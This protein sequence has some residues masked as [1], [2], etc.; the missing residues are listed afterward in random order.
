MA[1][2]VSSHCHAGVSEP[3]PAR[4]PMHHHRLIPSVEHPSIVPQKPYHHIP[5]RPRR[6]AHHSIRNLALGRVLLTPLDDLWRARA[7]VILWDRVHHHGYVIAAAEPGLWANRLA[8]KPRHTESYDPARVKGFRVQLGIFL[9][10]VALTDF[11]HDRQVA[12]LHIFTGVRAITG[13]CR[14]VR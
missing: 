10:K 1:H 7:P 8:S 2:L 5:G 13:R 9:F 6:A 12:F 14:E 4:P 3:R 11:R